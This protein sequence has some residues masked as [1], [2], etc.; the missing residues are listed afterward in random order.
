MI[1]MYPLEWFDSLIINSFDADN[2]SVKVSE[3]ELENLS[4]TIVSE[5][6][7]IKIHIKRRRNGRTYFPGSFHCKRNQ[8]AVS[9][10]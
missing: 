7:K 4:K 8:K 9:R 3:Y 2:S 5:S 10:F 6:K 1:K